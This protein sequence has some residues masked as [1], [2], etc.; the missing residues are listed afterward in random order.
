MCTSDE[1]AVS[2]TWKEFT[3]LSSDINGAHPSVEL[4]IQSVVTVG[5]CWLETCTITSSDFL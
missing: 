3:L 5:C 4:L 2:D 1:W